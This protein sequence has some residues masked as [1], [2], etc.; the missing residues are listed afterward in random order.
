[1]V[2]LCLVHPRTSELHHIT[3]QFIMLSLGLEHDNARSWC[4]SERCVLRYM[5]VSSL[6][7]H[8]EG[9]RLDAQSFSTV[10]LDICYCVCWDLLCCTIVCFTMLGNTILCYGMLYYAKILYIMKGYVSLKQSVLCYVSPYVVIL[11][12]ACTC[13]AM[14]RNKILWIY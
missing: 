14:L 4:M 9:F 5:H 12:S 10:I 1:M 6:E 3:L 8:G 11:C 2:C 13:S 7:G